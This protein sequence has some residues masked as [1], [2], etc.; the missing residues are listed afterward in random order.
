MSLETFLW[1]MEQGEMIQ[2]GR[3]VEDEMDAIA[4]DKLKAARE[5]PGLQKLAGQF[6]TQ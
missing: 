2:P 4:E 5:T 1:N 3:T 6:L